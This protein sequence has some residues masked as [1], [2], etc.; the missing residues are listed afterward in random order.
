[1]LTNHEPDRNIDELT[2]IEIYA[3]IHY[4]ELDSLRGNEH[5]DRASLAAAIACLIL[6]LGVIGFIWFYA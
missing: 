6:L 5:H 2:D 1:M 4:L 3:A